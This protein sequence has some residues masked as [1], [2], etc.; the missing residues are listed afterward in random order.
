[1]SSLGVCATLLQQRVWRG[2]LQLGHDPHEEFVSALA[3]LLWLAS[4][5]F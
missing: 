4:S 1:V 5:A 2:A 3:L